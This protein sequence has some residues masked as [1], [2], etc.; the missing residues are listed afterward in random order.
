MYNTTDNFPNNFNS[1]PTNP[2]MKNM[3]SL[4]LLLLYA[5]LL[6]GCS[7]N[8]PISGTVTFSDDGSPV[9][10]GLVT[11]D[12]G[13]FVARGAIG[14]DGRYVMGFE[15]ERDGVPPGTYAVTITG[16]IELLPCPENEDA[17][18]Y[19]DIYPPPS[20]QLIDLKY[21][22]KSTSELTITVDGSQ[23]TYHIQVDRA[24]VH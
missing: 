23:R 10:V 8:T 18:P 11:F 4:T 17:D 21:A 15:K 20:R 9:P 13:K 16:A 2:L 12:D 6:T 3:R 24:P 7:G 14:A 5:L 19:N 1:Q 22:D